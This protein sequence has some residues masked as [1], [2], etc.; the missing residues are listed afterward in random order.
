MTSLCL[1]CPNTLLQ[2]RTRETDGL[3]PSSTA[4]GVSPTS[5]SAWVWA[6]SLVR[7]N[8]LPPLHCPDSPLLT[9][10]NCQ[11]HRVLDR[12]QYRPQPHLYQGS[13]RPVPLLQRPCRGSPRPAGVAVLGGDGPQVRRVEPGQTRECNSLLCDSP[14][15]LLP[16][17]PVL[18]RSAGQEDLRQ[19]T[20]SHQVLGQQT[21]IPGASPRLRSIQVSLSVPHCRLSLLP[22][23]E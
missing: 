9:R 11:L 4:A 17:P 5:G 10:A 7:I 14:R 23:G 2:P 18:R 21:Q 20:G 15:S 1:T 19:D 3:T 8:P 16:L 22:P 6:G 13:V 12:A